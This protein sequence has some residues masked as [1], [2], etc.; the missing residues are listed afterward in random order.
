[1]EQLGPVGADW[2]WVLFGYFG[3]FLSGFM[4]NFIATAIWG[5]AMGYEIARGR[6]RRAALIFAGGFVV[7]LGLGALLVLSPPTGFIIGAPKR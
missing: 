6:R 3:F 5:A 4:L 7:V 2:R 1:M